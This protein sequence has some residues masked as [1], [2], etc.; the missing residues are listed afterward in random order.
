MRYA[1]VR[2]RRALGVR[3]VERGPAAAG[4]AASQSYSR[5]MVHIMAP[6]EEAL[7]TAHCELATPTF[8]GGDLSRRS[9]GSCWYM[10][11]RLG[12]ALGDSVALF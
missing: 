4:A 2:C 12:V 1:A 7:G 5:Q 10:N 9:R 6:P 8:W 3:G 11:S